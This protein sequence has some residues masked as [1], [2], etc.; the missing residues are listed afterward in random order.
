MRVT[1]MIPTQHTASSS[2]NNP[3][4]SHLNQNGNAH[5]D[6]KQSWKD[7]FL[8]LKLPQRFWMKRIMKFPISPLLL[9]LREFAR[10]EESDCL[11]DV[12]GPQ[13]R[14]EEIVEFVFRNIF[15]FIGI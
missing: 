14:Q 11:S 13:M 2:F 6:R 10:K 3:R 12:M 4:N 1:K 8:L 9:N 15:L 7:F 5:T